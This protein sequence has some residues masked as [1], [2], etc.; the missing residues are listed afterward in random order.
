MMPGKEVNAAM[1]VTRKF[2]L[3][4]V[5][6]VGIPCAGLI[7]QSVI[8]EM[9][10]EDVPFLMILLGFSLAANGIAFGVLFS[11]H[12]WITRRKSYP[13]AKSFWLAYILGLLAM[14]IVT[15]LVLREAALGTRGSQFVGLVFI[16]MP[17][18]TVPVM[19]VG[20]GIGWMIERFTRTKMV[21]GKS[22]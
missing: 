7:A 22:K 12:L 9:P 21:T 19:A 1:S 17:N 18:I 2:M 6:W 5:P 11:V 14:L 10:L 3:L 20:Y 16:Y 15:P 13:T 8:T 4:F